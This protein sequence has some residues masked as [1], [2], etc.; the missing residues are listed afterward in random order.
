MAPIRKLMLTLALTGL[1]VLPAAAQE[2]GPGGG[3]PGDPP[4]DTPGLAPYVLTAL[5]TGGYVGYQALKQAATMRKQ[6]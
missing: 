1:F 2:G 3:G 6:K 4:R 5:A